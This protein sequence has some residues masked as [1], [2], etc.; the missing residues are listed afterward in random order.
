MVHPID[1]IRC[2][3]PERGD[4]AVQ[5]VEARRVE[6]ARRRQAGD[7]DDLCVLQDARDHGRGHH[8]FVRPSLISL[9]PPLI[10]LIYFTCSRRGPEQAARAAAG[11]G[12]DLPAAAGRGRHRAR[13]RRLREL[14]Q[15]VPLRAHL[16]HRQFALALTLNHRANLYPEFQP[17]ACPDH[18]FQHLTKS[19]VA[20]YVKTLKEINVAFTPYESQ[21]FQLEDDDT[22]NV[23]YSPSKQAQV[24]YLTLTLRQFKLTPTRCR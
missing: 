3:H 15:D 14:A 19:S 6:R 21:V 10:V 4:P 7:E 24:C 9:R 18:A 23:V 1:L 13:C 2:R 20:K 12:G 11:A 5:E 8:Q 22:F 16:L 17:A